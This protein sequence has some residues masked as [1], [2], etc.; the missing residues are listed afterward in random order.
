M[1]YPVETFNLE[2]QISRHDKSIQV[3]IESAYKELSAFCDLPLN[4]LDPS[5]HHGAWHCR[6]CGLFWISRNC[7]YFFY[8]PAVPFYRTFFPG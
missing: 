7:L 8:I 2:Y 1:E 4:C 6:R 5:G 3:F